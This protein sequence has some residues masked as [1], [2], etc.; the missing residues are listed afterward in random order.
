MTAVGSSAVAAGARKERTPAVSAASRPGGAPIIAIVSLHSQ[1]ITVY[2]ASGWIIS[3]D[4]P[5]VPT[6]TPTTA[7]AFF[8]EWRGE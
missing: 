1:G 2:D 3:S 5:N 7:S 6:L 8:R 4:R